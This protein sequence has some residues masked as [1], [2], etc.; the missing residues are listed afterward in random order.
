MIDV[1]VIVGHHINDHNCCGKSW[2]YTKKIDTVE[3]EALKNMIND[4]LFIM[5]NVV[6][7]ISFS[8]IIFSIE[9][10]KRRNKTDLR[11]SDASNNKVMD[12]DKDGSGD[13]LDRISYFS[14]Y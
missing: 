11:Y 14:V 3:L 4:L 6:E 12:W 5:L 7:N 8:L 10:S 9:D 13:F 2:C 1:K